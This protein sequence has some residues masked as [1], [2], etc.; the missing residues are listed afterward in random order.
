[1]LTAFVVQTYELLQPPGQNMVTTNQLLLYGLSPQLEAARLSFPASINATFNALLSPMSFIPPLSARWI[2]GLFF[3]SLVLSLAAALFGILAKQWLREYLQ[4]NSPLSS[5]RENV[6]IRQIRS[7]ALS[8]WNIAS[9]ISTIPALLELA[10]IMF[11]VG[12][13]ILLWTLDNVLATIVTCF[14]VIL[15]GIASA[16]T[17]LPILFVRCP[18]KSPTAWA[19]VNGYH[20]ASAPIVYYTKR[21]YRDARII[22]FGWRYMSALQDKSFYSRCRDLFTT[23]W[24][25]HW[26]IAHPRFEKAAWPTRSRS[27]RERDLESIAVT[28]LAYQGWRKQ[29]MDAREAA[30][31]ELT[32]ELIPL[33]EDGAF[34]Q[35]PDP[36]D[37]DNT[38]ADALLLDI[39][40]TSLLLRA[41]SWVQQASQEP[42]VNNYVAECMDSIHRKFPA[43]PQGRSSQIQNVTNWCI[44]ASLQQGFLHEPHLALGPSPPNNYPLHSVVTN[45]RRATGVHSLRRGLSPGFFHQSNIN[46]QLGH[47][48]SQ[49]P[50]SHM[51]RLVLQFLCV[52]LRQSMTGLQDTEHLPAPHVGVEVR[53]IFEMFSL[54]HMIGTERSML[55]AE[56]YLD[57]LRAILCNKSLDRLLDAHAPSLRLGAFQLA[58]RYTAV[59]FDKGEGKLSQHLRLR[60]LFLC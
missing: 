12:I 35:D 15:L 18:Y 54:L 5:P 47:V 32:R 52:C 41:L 21:F 53:R 38:D 1:M 2:N 60:I 46:L 16:F 37:A 28:K 45:M 19:C 49:Y 13:V 25:D 26:A 48:D 7:E 44:I 3:V 40:E 59:T 24:Y 17:I 51:E 57:S 11:L 39:S 33:K 6:V 22:R 14:V 58:C 10:V 34:V 42:R 30:R 56:W 8:T 31:L 4:W 50:A 36:K 9:T 55:G 20:L 43:L 29:P 23:D 27:W